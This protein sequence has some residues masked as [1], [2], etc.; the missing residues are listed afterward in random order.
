MLCTGLGGE[1]ISQVS[2]CVP[3]LCVRAGEYRHAEN[4]GAASDI[5]NDL[6]LEQVGVLVY[7]IA[8]A[9][10]SHFIFLDA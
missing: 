1:P 7:G 5:K 3:V 2:A 4:R 8:V 9:L 6:V 10:G